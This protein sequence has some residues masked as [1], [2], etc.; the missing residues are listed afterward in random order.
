M[1]VVFQQWQVQEVLRKVF[2]MGK[3]QIRYLKIVA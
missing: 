1:L 3:A 2:I